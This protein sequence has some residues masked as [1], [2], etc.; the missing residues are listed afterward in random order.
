MDQT[1]SIET[2]KETGIIAVLRRVPKDDLWPLVETL[3]SSGV[4]VLELTVDNDDAYSSIQ[5]LRQ[6]YGDR[7]LVGAGTVIEPD[8]A[9]EALH[10]GAQFIFSPS[11]DEE[12]VKLTNE[13]GAISI[14][15][16]LTP[17]EI[18]QA[19]RAGADV[20]KIFPASAV[21]LNY[22]K[23]LQGPLGHIPM[24]PT[25]GVNVDNTAEFIKCG[26]IAVGVGGSLIDLKATENGDFDLIKEKAEA[27]VQQVKSGRGE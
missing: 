23:D 15:G 8:E 2:L 16:V 27:F 20:V 1:K 22:L 13:K 9:R 4:N 3:V 6:H 18:V 12:V 10:A 7:V 17:T 24:I 14:P 19:H 21:S 5:A 11:F 26:A 25:G